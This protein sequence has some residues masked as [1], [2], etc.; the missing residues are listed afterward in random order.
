MLIAMQAIVTKT[1]TE[2]IAIIGVLDARWITGGRLA[3]GLTA[4]ETGPVLVYTA[5]NPLDPVYPRI[6]ISWEG[7][8]LTT[9]LARLVA[10]SKDERSKVVEDAVDWSVAELLSVEDVESVAVGVMTAPKAVCRENEDVSVEA[11]ED[12]RLSRPTSVVE[13]SVDVVTVDDARSELLALESNTVS[14][15]TEAV[16]DVEACSSSAA[17]R[18]AP[19]VGEVVDDARADVE[20]DD[21]LDAGAADGTEDAVD[22][23]EDDA[24]DEKE[25]AGDTIFIACWAE[26][27]K[28]PG[29]GSLVALSVAVASSADAVLVSLGA[30]GEVDAE[31]TAASEMLDASVGCADDL[32]DSE[33]LVV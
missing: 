4:M 1:T 32:S 14:T 22:D 6:V 9:V 25:A 19:A 33:A 11:N 13:V 3:A 23:D 20:A 24:V 28:T 12:V 8:S 15:D 26:E 21:V 27:S 7:P 30:P 29:D 31:E 10:S 5:V 2:T 17:A 16:D 18:N